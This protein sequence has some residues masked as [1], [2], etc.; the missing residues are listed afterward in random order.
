LEQQERDQPGDPDSLVPDNVIDLEDET[1]NRRRR[2]GLALVTGAAGFVGSSIC[3][4]LLASGYAVQGIDSFTSNYAREAKL[5]NLVELLGTPGFRF[6]EDD[7][8]TVD[9]DALVDG[10]SLVFHEAGQPGVRTSWAS[11]FGSYVANNVVATQ[12]LLEAVVRSSSVE[13][14]VY[15]SSSSV[16]GDRVS[17]PCTEQTLPHP[18]SPYGVTK[19][20]AEHL[21]SLYAENHGAPVVSLRYFTVYGPRQRPDMAMHRLIRAALTG[22]SFPLFGDGSQ[23]RDF[24]FVGDVVRA[25]MLAAST[26]LEPGTVMN[27]S[28][29]GSVSMRQVIDLISELADEEVLIDRYPEVPGD[30]QR[31]GGTVDLARQLMGWEP[32]TE[33]HEGLRCQLTWQRNHLTRE[34][35]MP[36]A[37]RL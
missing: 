10:A 34:P 31:T 30:V 32:E 7:L 14:M 28:G 36:G 17:W 20:A 3:Q 13:R 18:L 26:D 19:L 37:D 22:T 9:V 12:R 2:A 24:T 5:S 15:A 29:V 25:N 21:C 4:A 27:V 23:I 6:L 35:A 16:Y 1:R 11:G 8:V 33:L